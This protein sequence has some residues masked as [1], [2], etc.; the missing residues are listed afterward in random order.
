M[1]YFGNCIGD[2]QPFCIQ[3]GKLN[4]DGGSCEYGMIE[5]LSSFHPDE[6]PYLSHIQVYDEDEMEIIG[7]YRLDQV[8]SLWAVTRKEAGWGPDPRLEVQ[9]G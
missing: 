3:L 1:G 8:A 6:G 4:Q 5:F 2:G 9:H 7:I